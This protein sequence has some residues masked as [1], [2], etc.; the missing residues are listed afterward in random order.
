MVNDTETNKSR[1]EF[2]Q[3]SVGYSNI[4]PVGAKTAI[5]CVCVSHVFCV[6]SYSSRRSSPSMYLR[7][8]RKAREL[9]VCECLI[10]T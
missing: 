10:R 5:L 9:K 2:D 8:R 7:L 1:T 3:G 4:S 6:W